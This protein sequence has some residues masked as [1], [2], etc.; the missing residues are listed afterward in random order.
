M[1]QLLWKKIWLFCSV[2]VYIKHNVK[3][4]N[5]RPRAKCRLPSS[6]APLFNTLLSNTLNL[7]Y[8][9]NVR[10]QVSYTCNMY[11]LLFVFVL[12]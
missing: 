7:C 10:D 4:P 5:L 1:H 6:Q 2:T 9:L 12:V 3:S 8:S 11:P